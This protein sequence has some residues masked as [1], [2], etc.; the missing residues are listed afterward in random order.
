MVRP[1]VLLLD[2]LMKTILYYKAV[3]ISTV[4]NDFT[5]NC[6][7]KAYPSSRP[8]L[9]KRTYFRL[10]AKSYEKTWQIKAFQKEIGHQFRYALYQNWC[11]IMVPVTGHLALRASARLPVAVPE[12]IFGLALLLDFFDRGHSLTSLH[13]PPAALSS[14]P[15]AKNPSPAARIFGASWVEPPVLV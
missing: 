8:A 15:P 13:P 4:L 11:P 6:D 1:V 2:T 5:G 10:F 7:K 9:K 3:N 14:L 12:K